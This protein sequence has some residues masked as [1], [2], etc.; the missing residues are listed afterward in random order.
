MAGGGV[1]CHGLVLESVGLNQLL[2][3]PPV[4]LPCVVIVQL[5]QA[6]RQEEENDKRKSIRSATS[7]PRSQRET[8]LRQ[9]EKMREMKVYMHRNSLDSF[10]HICNMQAVVYNLK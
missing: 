3:L 1:S 5:V 10:Q 2:L 7:G 9:E 4:L 8:R 6:L